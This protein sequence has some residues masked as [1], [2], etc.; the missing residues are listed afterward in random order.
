M[1]KRVRSLQTTDPDSG[2]KTGLMSRDW[3]INVLVEVKLTGV[4]YIGI[5]LQFSASPD[6]FC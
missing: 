6:I 1:Q 5:L 4:R 3:R 2:G